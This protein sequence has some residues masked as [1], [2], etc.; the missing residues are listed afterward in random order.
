[1][2]IIPKT[3]FL[4]FIGLA[5][6]THP[7]S[8]ADLNTHSVTI[9]TPL[10]PIELYIVSIIATIGLICFAITRKDHSAIWISALSVFSGAFCLGCSFAYGRAATVID[11]AVFSN[12]TAI[13]TLTAITNVGCTLFSVGLFIFAVIMLL[14]AV[15]TTWQEESKKVM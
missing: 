1:M 15:L 8:A 13:T 9:Q 11:T 7:V 12:S 5:A 10:V 4:V 6:L 2:K 14:A 3:L